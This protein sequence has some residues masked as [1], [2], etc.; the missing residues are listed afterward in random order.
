MQCFIVT[1]IKV[2][3]A[4]KTSYR[5]GKKTVKRR[6][7]IRTKGMKQEHK[8]NDTR[9]LSTG[10]PTGAHVMLVL[11]TQFVVW[12]WLVV[13]RLSCWR[14]TLMVLIQT[15]ISHLHVIKLDLTMEQESVLNVLHGRI[16]HFRILYSYWNNMETLLAWLDYLCSVLCVRYKG[17]HSSHDIILDTSTCIE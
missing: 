3:K 1:Q 6:G 9:W 2:T 12:V 5:G 4:G 15:D 13:S 16:R 7:D 8:I 17:L 14:A 10:L 11:L